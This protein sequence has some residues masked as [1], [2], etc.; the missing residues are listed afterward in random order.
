MKCLQRVTAFDP[1]TPPTGMSPMRGT[2]S[3]PTDK[4]AKAPGQRQAYPGDRVEIKDIG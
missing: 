4:A 2:N 3:V 1:A